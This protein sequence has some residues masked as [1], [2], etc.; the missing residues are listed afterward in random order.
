MLLV[1]FPDSKEDKKFYDSDDFCECEN[2]TCKEETNA[3]TYGL[4][5][6]ALSCIMHHVTNPMKRRFRVLL[7]LHFKVDTFCD[8]PDTNKVMMHEATINMD[9]N[10]YLFEYL[11]KKLADF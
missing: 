8:I 3:L 11:C 4:V 5:A 7:Q 10:D 9:E 1:F 6:R 2:K